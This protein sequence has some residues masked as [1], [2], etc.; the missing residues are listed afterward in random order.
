[1]GS[2]VF[3]RNKDRMV[4]SHFSEFFRYKS[5]LFVANRRVI[6][7]Y[8]TRGALKSRRE[9]VRPIGDLRNGSNIGKYLNII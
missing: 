6:K 3:V 7:G 8:V 1:M 5:K 9:Q 4:L 2:Y